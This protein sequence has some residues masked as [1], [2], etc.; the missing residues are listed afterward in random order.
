MSAHNAE[1]QNM[2]ARESELWGQAKPGERTSWLESP[3]IYRR[4]NLQISGHPD[5]DCLGYIKQKYFRKPAKLGLNVG[6][7][8]GE[9]EQLLVKRGLVETMHGFDVSSG[10]V[11][12]AKKA[13]EKAGLAD[14]IQ[15]FVAD[16]NHLDDA[17]L[18][19]EYDVAYGFMAL[20]HIVDLE[21]CLDGI[22]RRLKPGGILIA[23]EFVGPYRFQWTDKQLDIANQLL[24]CFPVE[25]TRNIR[26]PEKLKRE[27]ERPS[28]K[29]MKKYMA[30]ESVCS[31]R[32]VKALHDR[33]EILEQK[34][35]GGTILHILFEAIMGNFK[36]ETNR[37]HA[38]LV[39]MASACEETLLKHGGLEH[40]HTFMI[41][42]KK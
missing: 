1:Y 14:R 9:L 29:F 34:N 35:Y 33:Y 15:Y 7:G 40:D 2:L 25:L 5:V 38:A 23:N 26:E 27:V 17:P 24:Q 20:H 37:E 3:L 13:A 41:C 12:A 32:I 6:C 16:A 36:E 18:A 39:R 4:V 11:E 31:D 21:A 19:Q 8:H 30:F 22:R 10:A 42:K 28:I